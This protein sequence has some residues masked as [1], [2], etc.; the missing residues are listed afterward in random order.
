MTR[1]LP[2][3][4]LLG[5]VFDGAKQ[6]AFPGLSR[7]A[8]RHRASSRRQVTGLSALRR[9]EPT[10]LGVPLATVVP[11]PGPT[12][13]AAPAD[14]SKYSPRKNCDAR[15]GRA[16]QSLRSPVCRDRRIDNAR[17]SAQTDETQER[18]TYLSQ[19]LPVLVKGKA[20]G[21]LLFH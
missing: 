12:L 14:P 7:R 15:N 3:V 11:R 8:P 17:T 19:T 4:R 5:R 16:R 10:L 2:T 13:S 1:P 20:Q 18:L 6:T 9:P 21:E